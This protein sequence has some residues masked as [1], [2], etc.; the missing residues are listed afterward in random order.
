MVDVNPY[1]PGDRPDYVII[2]Q[3]YGNGNSGEGTAVPAVSHSF[4]EL[5]NPTDTPVSLSGMSLQY[6]RG[7]SSNYPTFGD[8]EKLDL[9]CWR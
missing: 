6:I 5:Y 3:V 4:I 8:W 1:K 2:N 9:R 7:I